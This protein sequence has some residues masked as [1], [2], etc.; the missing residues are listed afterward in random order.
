MERPSPP[1]PPTPPRATTSGPPSGPP[2]GQPSFD[3]EKL[4]G[5]R[6]AAIAGAVTL[7]IAAILLARLAIA[8]GY[9]T[10][11]IRV[12]L[13]LLA[14]VGGLVWAELS[15]RRGYA[16]T[17]NAVSGAGIAVLYVAF[18]A[19]HSLYGLLPLGLTSA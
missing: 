1:V 12:A 2:S 8:S 19:A 5:L 3:W 4:L 17:A 6:G 9:V 7:V 15:L 10:P 18:F 14:G 16:T 13:M 11:E